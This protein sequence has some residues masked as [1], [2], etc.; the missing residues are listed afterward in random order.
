MAMLTLNGQVINCFEQPAFT[1]KKTGEVTP[2]KHRVQIM[3]ENLLQNG[4]NRME[5]VNLTVDDIEPYQKLQGRAVR[6][7]VGAFANG[8]SIQF[9]ALK[10]HRPEAVGDMPA[11]SAR[12]F[13]PGGSPAA[14]AAGQVRN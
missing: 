9:Y 4:S 14:P 1:D 13:A 6:V 10:A 11:A 12:G 3:A 5:L 8:S 2:G 7:P